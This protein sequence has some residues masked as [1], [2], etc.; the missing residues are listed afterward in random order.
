MSMNAQTLARPYAR[1]AFD[2]AKADGLLAD[3][4]RRLQLSAQV[5][6]V[7]DVAAALMRPNM[8][9]SDQVTLLLPPGDTADGTYGRFLSVVAENKRLALLPDIA[10]QYEVLRAEDERIVKARVRTAVA[11]EPAQIETLK[12]ALKRRFG[13]E[14]ELDNEIDAAVLGGAVIDAGDIVIDGSVRGRLNKLH[15]VLAH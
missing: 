12:S 9:Q 10:A 15:N 2:L 4:S 6:S 14:V 11:L 1:A 8:P 3:W 13:R 7:P 5:A